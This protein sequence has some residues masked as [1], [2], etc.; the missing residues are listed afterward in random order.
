M[1][2]NRNQARDI[3]F[4]VLI[5]VILLA[6]VFTMTSQPDTLAEV[7]DS[8]I[9][10]LFKNEQVEEVSMVGNEL[11]LKLYEPFN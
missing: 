9:D 6:T 7:R 10:N 5:L 11:T 2:K 3:G 8:D 1:K 4:Y